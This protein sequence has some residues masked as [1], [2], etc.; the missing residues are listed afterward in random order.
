MF[1]KAVFHSGPTEPGVLLVFMLAPWKD[2]GAFK[3]NTALINVIGNT[4]VYLLFHITM[5]ATES[6]TATRISAFFTKAG[7]RL[8]CCSTFLRQMCLS[9][10]SLLDVLTELWACA[11]L[12]IQQLHYNQC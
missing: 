2:S 12:F 11:F 4:H 7:Q 9:T 5:A 3:W 1:M 6:V 8:S 10:L